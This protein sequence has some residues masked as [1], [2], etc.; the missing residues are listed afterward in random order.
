MWQTGV[1]AVLDTTMTPGAIKAPKGVKQMVIMV[2]L[3]VARSAVVGFASK[4]GG[5]IWGKVTAMV[6]MFRKI[7]L[8]HFLSTDPPLKVK[9]V[10]MRKML[11]V[12]LVQQEQYRRR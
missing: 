9:Q 3:S 8:S 6:F 1:E 5:P 10:V 11:Q 2:M 4:I 12:R 7:F